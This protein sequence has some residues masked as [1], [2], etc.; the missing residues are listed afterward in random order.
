MSRT[1]LCLRIYGPEELLQF[2]GIQFAIGSNAAAQIEP[3][4]LYGLDGLARVTRM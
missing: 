4:R 3:E 1:K 2:P